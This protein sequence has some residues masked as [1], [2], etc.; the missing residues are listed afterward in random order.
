M[1]SHYPKGRS[2]SDTYNKKKKSY[3]QCD[4]SRCYHNKAY[5]KPNDLDVE[6]SVKK[7][8][9]VK[10]KDVFDQTSA[11]SRFIYLLAGSFSPGF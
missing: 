5:S 11:C 2:Q 3:H 9:E 4:T 8:K 10:E 6:G 1:P 7:D